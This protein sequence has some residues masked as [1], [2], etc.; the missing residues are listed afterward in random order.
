[1]ALSIALVW[2]LSSR[3]KRVACTL[4]S[5]SLSVLSFFSRAFQRPSFRSISCVSI[6]RGITGSCLSRDVVWKSFVADFAVKYFAREGDKTQSFRGLWCS[7]D[8]PKFT[9]EIDAD[10]LRTEIV[11]NPKEASLLSVSWE[12]TNERFLCESDSRIG[13]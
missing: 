11:S 8:N 12:I 1:M 7:P 4:L 13:N 2:F 10:L 9:I 6:Y 5:L 3:F